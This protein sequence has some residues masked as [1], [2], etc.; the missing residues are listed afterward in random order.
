MFITTS[1]IVLSVAEKDHSDVD[2]LLVT[3]LTHGVTSGLLVA[4]DSWYSFELLWLP[5]TAE[6]CVS[7]VGKPKIFIIQVSEFIFVIFF[8]M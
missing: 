2:C 8:I 7:L 3:V 5:F 4:Y 1:F 6:K